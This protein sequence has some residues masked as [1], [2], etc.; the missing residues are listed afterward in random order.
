MFT[1]LLAYCRVSTTEQA[2][3]GTT[4]LEEQERKARAVALARGVDRF[5]VVIYSDPGVSGSIPLAARPEGA[6]LLSDARPGDIIVAAKLDRL[7]RS[8]SDALATVRALQDRKVDVILVDLG[9][10]P[11]GASSTARLFFGMLSVFAEFE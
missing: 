6:R 4:S 8:A 3:D 1:M 5:D 7:F 2:A 11:V 9:T 10:D